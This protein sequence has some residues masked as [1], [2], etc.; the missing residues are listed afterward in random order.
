MF[1]LHLGNFELLNY[2]SKETI[3]GTR[4]QYCTVMNL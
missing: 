1:S 2:M 4:S 3:P